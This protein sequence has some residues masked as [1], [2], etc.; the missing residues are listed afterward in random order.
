MAR[1]SFYFLFL[2]CVLSGPSLSKNY[3][4]SQETNVTFKYFVAGLPLEGEFRVVESKFDI[5]FQ[6]PFKSI[7]SVKFDLMQSNAGFPLATK[8]MKKVLDAY[9]F[10]SVVFESGSVKFKDESF[11]IV[12][13]LKIRNV[14]KPVNL[15][16]TV[17]ENYS[18]DSETI[19]FSIR[20]SFNRRQFGADGYYPL[21]SDAIIIEDVLTINKS[22]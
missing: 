21:V 4:L 7:F 14:S 15:I 20:A 8:A 22:Q 12:G 5:N 1:L 17:L 11:Q 6:Y 13:L 18:S 16:V 10:P 19:R 9:R 2:L 3:Q